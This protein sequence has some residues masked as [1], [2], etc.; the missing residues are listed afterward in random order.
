MGQPDFGQH[1]GADA[2]LAFDRQP[3]ADGHHALLHIGQPQAPTGLAG[4]EPD[5]VVADDQRHL[6]GNTTQVHVHTGGPGVSGH[7]VQCLL[8][9]AVERLGHGG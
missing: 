1:R 2:G 7:V 4:V 6:L 3:P 5:A 8:G 9:H